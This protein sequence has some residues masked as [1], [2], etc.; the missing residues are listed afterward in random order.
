M[1]PSFRT[2]GFSALLLLGVSA[3]ASAP[4]EVASLETPRP[5][6][7]GAIGPSTSEPTL[8]SRNGRSVAR[9]APRQFRP[10][11]N[12]VNQR[13]PAIDRALSGRPSGY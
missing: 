4:L 11:S 8:S 12:K 7:F 9:G 6:R 13:N 5:D 10:L 2:I 3:C 1:R